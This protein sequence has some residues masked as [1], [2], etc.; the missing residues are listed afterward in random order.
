MKREIAESRIRHAET[1]RY[2]GWKQVVQKEQEQL[3]RIAKWEEES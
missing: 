3:A 1:D 2:R